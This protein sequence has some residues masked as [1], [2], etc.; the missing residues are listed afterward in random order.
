MANNPARKVNHYNWIE[1]VECKDVVS[2][3]SYN[4]GVAIAYI[5]RHLHKGS[6][7]E[8]LEKA[9]DHLRYEIDVIKALPNSVPLSARPEVA[10]AI[11]GG[12]SAPTPDGTTDFQA[13]TVFEQLQHFH[14]RATGLIRDMAA[15]PGRYSV[16]SVEKLLQGWVY[17]GGDNFTDGCSPPPEPFATC[18]PPIPVFEQ[19]QRFKHRASSMLRQ[20]AEKPGLYSPADVDAALRGWSFPAPPTHEEGGEE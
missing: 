13:P 8:D 19:L 16:E 14:F 7:I 3:F 5:W 6:M 20:M 15:R 1:G 9:V 18:S 11:C 10:D 17:E 4:T 12:E 2:H